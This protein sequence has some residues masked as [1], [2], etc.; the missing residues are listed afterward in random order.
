M[1]K[2]AA[3]HLDARY[4]TLIENAYYYSNPPES[5][6]EER[7]QRPPMHQYIRRLLYRDLNK[8]NT[9]RIIR[10]LRKLNWEDESVGF[11][12]IFLPNPLL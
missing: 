8:V 1:R 12:T 4:V 5:K 11:I 2:K 6:M 9:E 7:K 10:Q 3:L